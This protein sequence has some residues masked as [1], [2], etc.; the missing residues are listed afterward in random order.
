MGCHQKAE[1]SFFF[2]GYQFPVCARCTGVLTASIVACAIFSVYR[3]E[4]E[5]CVCLGFIMLA[6]WTVQKIGFAKSTN[7]RRLVTGLAGGYGCMT[8][9]LYLYRAFVEW[10]IDKFVSIWR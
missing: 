1:R 7:V 10:I 9:Q 8:L 2:R 4:W 3:L 5:W 6:D